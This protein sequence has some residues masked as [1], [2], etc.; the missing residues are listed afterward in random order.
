[1]IALLQLLTA[2]AIVPVFWTLVGRW[3]GK[4]YKR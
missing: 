1:M 2:L 4:Q 3:G